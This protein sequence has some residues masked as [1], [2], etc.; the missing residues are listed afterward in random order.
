[1]SVVSLRDRRVQRLVVE[2]KQPASVRRTG[3]DRTRVPALDQAPEEVGGFLPVGDAG[4]MA[5]LALDEYPAV[6]QDLDE[7]SRLPWCEAEGTNCLTAFVGQ[8]SDVPP[9]RGERKIHQRHSS[10]TRGLNGA[11][12]L[13]RPPP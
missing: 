5:I 12:P 10:A 11:V 3:R 8:T 7:E 2:V 6:D 13:V 1:M 4:E 9:V